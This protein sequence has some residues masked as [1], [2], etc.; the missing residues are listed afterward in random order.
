MTKYITNKNNSLMYYFV[1]RNENLQQSKISNYSLENIAVLKLI[2]NTM[3]QYRTSEKRVLRLIKE[4]GT[5][6]SYIK[7]INGNDEIDRK[8][9]F[10][11]IHND[12]IGLV[13]DFNDKK[14]LLLMEML[15]KKT[16][17]IHLHS[18]WGYQ[19]KENSYIFANKKVLIDSYK[20][21][22][23]PSP[24][25]SFSLTEEEKLQIFSP[26]TIT[27]KLQEYEKPKII[28]EEFVNEIKRVFD[29]PVLMAI[30]VGFACCFFDI[31]I[32]KTQGFPYII[33]YG[34]SNAGKS[35]ILHMLASFYGLTNMT[36]L[37]SG[38]STGV[39]LR[40][41]LEKQN[42]ML[43][44]YEEIDRM[45][46]NYIED[47]GKD[48]FSATP[49]KKL[50]KD[51]KEIISEI[52]TS[53]CVG[54]NHFFE[55]MSFANFSRC[56]PVNLKRRKFDLTNFKYHSTNEL[57][58]LSSFL[59]NILFYRDKIFDIYQKQYKIVQKHCSYAR[60]C[61]NVAI[62]MTIWNIINDILEKE[63]INT[64]SLAKNYLDYFEQYLDTELSYGDIFLSD[65]YSLFCK[66]ELIYGRDFLITKGKYLRINLTKYCDVFNSTHENKKLNP[67]QI[68]LKLTNDKRVRCLK[69]S[70]LK[71]IGKAIKIDISQNEIL[72]DILNR[73]TRTAE[74]ED[75]SNE[76]NS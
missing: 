32:S 38:T 74:E 15:N 20:I 45:K 62:G 12:T 70:D 4:G 64:E 37:T 59:P 34:E 2:T 76:Y 52:N 18:N 22:D 48:C 21:E 14:F 41:Q 8:S 68:R 5:N 46:I 31:F 63:V 55:E 13:E 44:F 24:L 66:K 9:F 58:K 71:P 10:R 16:Q 67:A 33:L 30:A 42:N 17:T 27:P 7:I 6:E 19:S 61:N 23:Y 36:S 3:N 49:R 50:S 72:L 69:G 57:E 1:D 25:E 26:N 65:V 39:G 40:T 43:V 75:I 11:A 47:L 56:I 35:T 54:T 51:G 53:F 60:I 28:L 29:A 73:I